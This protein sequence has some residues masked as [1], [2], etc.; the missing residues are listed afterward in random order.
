MTKIITI[1]MVLVFNC[2]TGASLGAMVGIEPIV[3]ALGMNAVGIAAS[4]IGT[5]SG[6]RAGVFTE[7]WT[8]ELVKALRA[9]LEGT[10]LDGIP[11]ATSVVKNSVIHLV[12]V[13]VD[14]DVLINNTT[15]PIEVQ[16]L[17]DGDIAITLDK[18]QS[19]ATPI[20]DDELY[21]VSYDKIARVKESHGNAIQD[22]KFSKA[23]HSI[24]SATNKIATS[25]TADPATGRKKLV[26][27]DIIA[28]KTK[29]DKMGIPVDGRRLVL[30]PDHVNDLLA[31]SETFTRQYNL[32]TVNGR[33]ARLYG[34][35]IYEYSNCPVFNSSG[36]KQALG[37]AEGSGLFQAS[38]AFY[39]KRIFK[40]SGETK[41]YFSEA[42]NDPLTQRN[43]INFRHM[44]IAMPKKGDASVT[45]YNGYESDAAPTITGDVLLDNLSADAGSNVRTYGTSNGA[46]VTAQ[47][48]SPWL[49]VAVAENGK[50]VTFTRE[51]Y[52]HA[53]SGD[54]PRVAHVTVAIPDTTATLDVVVKQAMAES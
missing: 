17:S 7:I 52:A 20:T 45:L 38:F 6:L 24:A 53:D 36:V 12:D 13:G 33:C 42:K 40:A 50:K 30:C 54:N 3:G 32:D 11:D 35:D 39:A 18:F 25:G 14:P 41:M 8:G 19:K 47:S 9:G 22:A 4:F 23:A 51:A 1:L 29:M 5:P 31:I 46:A 37:T 27:A 49:T 21:A 44:F 16:E 48:D 28:V 10:W 15:Y 26:I 43:L 34:F 2:F